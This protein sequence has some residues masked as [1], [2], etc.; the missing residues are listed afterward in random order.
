MK[1]FKKNNEQ[2][3]KISIEYELQIKE[4]IEDFK[5]LSIEEQEIF[6]KL[7]SSIRHKECNR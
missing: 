7:L 6:S 1:I 3:T 4:I 5:K 2:N